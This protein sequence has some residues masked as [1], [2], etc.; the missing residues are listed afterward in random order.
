MALFPGPWPAWL[1]GL[2]CDFAHFLFVPHEVPVCL[3]YIRPLCCLA[4]PGF[5]CCSWCHR[6]PG[7]A[8]GKPTRV[9]TVH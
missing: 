3:V 8:G 7:S 5:L 6:G 4:E 9:L 2:E 1:M